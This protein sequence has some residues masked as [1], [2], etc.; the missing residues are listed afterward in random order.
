MLTVKQDIE[1]KIQKAAS[2][3]AANPGLSWA[4]ASTSYE[5]EPKVYVTKEMIRSK[6]FRSLSRVAFIVLLDFME[7]RKMVKAGYEKTRD[8]GKRKKWVCNNNGRLQYPYSDALDKGISRTQFRNAIDELQRKGFIDITHRGRGG[9]KPKDGSGDSTM[10]ALDDR[11]HEYDS[12]T[13]MSAIP[14]K[15]PRKK[16]N[17]MDRGFQKYWAE[18]KQI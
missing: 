11:W 17:R 4:N 3:E 1:Q 18:K 8:G 15:M 13:G 16:D 7:K 14:P 10:Y 6:A 9:R 2:W 12:A 5:D